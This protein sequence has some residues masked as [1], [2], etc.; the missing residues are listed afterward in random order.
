M[1]FEWT[2]DRTKPTMTISSYTVDNNATTNDYKIY[3]KLEA[4]EDI[5][6][7]D[8]NDVT[9]ISS[10]GSSTYNILSLRKKVHQIIFLN[11]F[12]PYNQNLLNNIHL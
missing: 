7:F 11:L 6:N 4:N 10:G 1:F 5:K 2:S 3:L 12:Q 8:V 9:V